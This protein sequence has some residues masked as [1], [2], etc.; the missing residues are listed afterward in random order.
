LAFHLSKTPLESTVKQLQ[1]QKSEKV[2][3]LGYW[4]SHALSASF[5]TKAFL[6][7]EHH[8][9]YS[10]LYLAPTMQLV[11]FHPEWAWIWA[12]LGKGGIPKATICYCHRLPKPQVVQGK[13]SPFVCSVHT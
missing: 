10:R 11:P 7:K 6:T 5:S 12:E 3:I 8:R 9:Y 1:V 2:R 4:F 13:R